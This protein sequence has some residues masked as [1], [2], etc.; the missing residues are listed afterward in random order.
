MI[1]AAM[2]EVAGYS[3]ATKRGFNAARNNAAP[4]TYAMPAKMPARCPMKEAFGTRS[5]MMRSSDH[6]DRSNMLAKLSLLTST[7]RAKMTEEK[8]TAH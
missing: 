1:N 5:W 6:T 4:H 3:T 7:F 8:P 2:P